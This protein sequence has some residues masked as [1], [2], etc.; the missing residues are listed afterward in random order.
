M[1]LDAADFAPDYE[2][3]DTPHTPRLSYAQLQTYV[4]CLP[5]VTLEKLA[6]GPSEGGCVDCGVCW[7]LEDVM[8]VH[9]SEP[10][11][12]QGDVAFS[13]YVLQNWHDSLAHSERFHR[14]L[15][16]KFTTHPFV[17]ADLDFFEEECKEVLGSVMYARCCAIYAAATIE[18]NKRRS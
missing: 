18:L 8:P 4:S 16:E 11:E 12:A 3:Y 5:D 1:P 13:A 14:L 17:K 2:P 7:A 15:T 10:P 6:M 9:P